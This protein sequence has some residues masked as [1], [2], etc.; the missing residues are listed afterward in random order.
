MFSEEKIFEYLKLL[1]SAFAGAFFAY[2]FLRISDRVKDKKSKRKD[3]IRSLS[4]IQFICNENYNLL[5]DSLFVIDQISSV[6]IEARRRNQSPYSVNRLDRI[7][8]DKEILLYLLNIDF[9]ND[10]FSYTVMVEK[11][12][13]D[14]DS[15][16]HFHES[17]QMA[18]LSGQIPVENYNE[19]MLRFEND[20]K[21]FKNLCI[22][23]MERTE[24]IVAKCRVI[25]KEEDRFFRKFLRKN[26]LSY[27]KIFNQKLEEELKLLKKE[28]QK[29]IK[30]S[31]EKIDKA[32]SM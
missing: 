31:K 25:L 8:N 20:I 17:M 11:H 16:N 24:D 5:N 10:Y 3:S 22:D 1:T 23:A 27:N 2:I 18:R 19:N 13:N 6:I 30:D 7:T 28:K 14:V 9:L 4:K 26:Y 32:L 29:I 15:F 21:A 12:N